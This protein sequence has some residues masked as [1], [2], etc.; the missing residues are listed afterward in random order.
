MYMYLKYEASGNI[1]LPPECMI[2]GQYG[3]P[4]QD[5]YELSEAEWLKVARREAERGEHVSLEKIDLQFNI[6]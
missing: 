6:S 4:H 5:V 2:C 1:V 3:C